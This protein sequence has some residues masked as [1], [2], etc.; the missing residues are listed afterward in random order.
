ME[1]LQGGERQEADA[2]HQHGL[3]HWLEQQR[4]L[5]AKMWEKPHRNLSSGSGGITVVRAM[6]PSR[7]PLSNTV[8]PGAGW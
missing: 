7:N 4:T 8:R 5:P 6:T 1:G 3:S 2:S